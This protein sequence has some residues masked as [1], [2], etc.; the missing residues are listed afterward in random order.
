MKK[1]ELVDDWKKAHR[2]WSVI[3]SALGTAL[4]GLFTVWPESALYLWQMMPYEVKQIMPSNIATAIAMVIF[5]MSIASR[6][7]KQKRLRDDE[8]Q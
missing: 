6:L 1:L 3:F 8:D 4:M 2:F 5:I 7:I